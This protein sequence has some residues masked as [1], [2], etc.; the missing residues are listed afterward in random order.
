MRLHLSTARSIYVHAL[1]I[2]WIEIGHGFSIWWKSH[3]A[4]RHVTSL[5]ILALHHWIDVLTSLKPL[6]TSSVIVAL[7]TIVSRK[8]L[9]IYHG[10]H[11]R[12]ALSYTRD[13]FRRV[14]ERKL[15]PWEIVDSLSVHVNYVFGTRSA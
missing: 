13:S 14:S 2:L 11:L 12:E 6:L 15:A 4:A 5:W 3:I 8:L 1:F 7:S 9:R 10:Q